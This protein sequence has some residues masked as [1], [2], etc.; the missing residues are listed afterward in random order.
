MILL[1]DESTQVVTSE[2]SAMPPKAKDTATLMVNTDDPA[3]IQA[4]VKKHPDCISRLLA[5]LSEHNVPPDHEVG[6]W[7]MIW[8]VAEHCN[9][10]P[11]ME[12][13]PLAHMQLLAT[14]IGARMETAKL[15]R[16]G[17]FPPTMVQMLFAGANWMHNHP[18]VDVAIS[19]KGLVPNYAKAIITFINASPSNRVDQDTRMLFAG[20][21]QDALVSL[22]LRPRPAPHEDSLQARLAFVFN[23]HCFEAIMKIMQQFPTNHE[24]LGPIKTIFEHL[25][26]NGPTLLRDRFH[27]VSSAMQAVAASVSPG[28]LVQ[29]FLR[30]YL[31]SIAGL[32]DE[33][34]KK[35]CRACSK[36]ELESPLQMCAKCKQSFYC[37]RQCQIA[38]WPAHK[39]HCKER[40]LTDFDALEATQSIV[41]A[42][43]TKNYL[44]IFQQLRALY[45]Q[46]PTLNLQHM[47]VWVDPKKATFGVARVDD[48]LCGRNLPE[49]VF[50]P[51]EKGM[52]H[53]E[54]NV[55]GLGEQLRLLGA[56]MEP[57]LST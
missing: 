34:R 16:D 38:D 9:H 45:T 48:W 51:A 15:K 5:Q 53:Y 2:A 1:P 44:P 52:S 35:M 25:R 28:C 20:L 40:S 23:T 7:N 42:V 32:L 6:L 57:S 37:S 46:D 17:A 29:V 26:G 43:V 24:V 27:E 50:A 30:D 21:V 47:L 36:S 41:S 4:Y 13:I 39:Q 3:S 54:N 12:L 8:A 31:Q 14:S 56:K 49:H 18:F 55:A 19:E 22:A 11:L 33:T 10:T